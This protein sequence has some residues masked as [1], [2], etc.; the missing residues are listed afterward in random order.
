MVTT[1]C[2]CWNCKNALIRFRLLKYMLNQ[3]L[4]N[5]FLFVPGM[6]LNLTRRIKIVKLEFITWANNEQRKQATAGSGK[7]HCVE[8]TWARCIWV[9]L[10]LAYIDEKYFVHRAP[11]CH[12]NVSIISFIYTA[13]L[14][15]RNWDRKPRKQSYPEL[16]YVCQKLIFCKSKH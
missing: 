1:Y 4:C 3:A 10:H 12:G 15:T 7:C 6:I 11:Y 14:R 5:R 8:L 2:S 13:I 9:C 16:F